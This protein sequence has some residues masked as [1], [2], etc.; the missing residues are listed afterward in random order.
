LALVRQL[1]RDGYFVA[2]NYVNSAAAAESLVGELGPEA[3]GAYRC[4]VSAYEP[5]KAMV[6]DVFSKQGRLDVLVSNAGLTRDKSLMMMSPEDWQEV[7]NVNLT[8]AFN[9]SKAVIVPMLKAKQGRIVYLSS[10]TGL[11]GMK[12][13][14]NYAASKAGLI[15]MTKALAKEV[16]GYGITVNAVAPGFIEGDMT[17]QT[18]EHYLAELKPHIP[19]KRLGTAVEVAQLVSYLVSESAAYITGE[20]IRIDGGVAI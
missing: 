19:Q 15:G 20:V 3:I 13:Q 14:V 1:V 7:I 4:D 17:A 2:F 9:V 6:D 18:G 11:V 12:G 5:I 8:G 16:A 10:V